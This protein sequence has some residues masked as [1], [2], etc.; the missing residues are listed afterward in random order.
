MSTSTYYNA[1]EQLLTIY[2]ATSIALTTVFT[3]PPACV[4]PTYTASTEGFDKWDGFNT[5]LRGYQESCFPPGYSL[6]AWTSS[7]G[8][9]TTLT[10][11]HRVYVTN[12]L[13][14][15]SPG[16]CPDG[17]HTIE[18]TTIEHSTDPATTVATCCP[19]ADMLYNTYQDLCVISTN[20]PTYTFLGLGSLA[21]SSAS[22]VTRGA[23]EA[24]VIRV[25]WQD[26][27]LG[28][29]Q[30][31]TPAGMPALTPASATVS[32]APRAGASTSMPSATASMPSMTSQVQ[33]TNSASPSSAGVSPMTAAG[34]GI[35]GTLLLVAVL[36]AVLFLRR[37]RRNAAARALQDSKADLEDSDSHHAQWKA[38][39]GAEERPIFEKSGLGISRPLPEMESRDGV[40]C[41]M[42][43]EEA[44]Y[45]VCGRDK[46]HELGPRTTIVAELDGDWRGWEAPP[47][48]PKPSKPRE[49]NMF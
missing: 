48:P 27:D 23:V 5:A 26:S 10:S 31:N 39:L 1:T 9:T 40:P 13:P 16:V 4:A 46:A 47:V 24:N 7:P 43:G 2:T 45:E 49:S 44:S 35:G 28:F 19:Q 30:H 29:F 37:R 41:E 33:P 3:P 14:Y 22:I 36:A 38:E 11:E 42:S 12:Y 6:I 18:Q 34:I 8:Q 32:S 21:L 25:A 17:Y 20:A 15:F